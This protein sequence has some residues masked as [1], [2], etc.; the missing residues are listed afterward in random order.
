MAYLNPITLLNLDLAGAE[1]QPASEW[2]KREK[3]R[4]LAEFE[5]QDSPV[6][7]INEREIDRATVL[8]LF[9]SLEDHSEWQNHRLVAER[10]ALQAFLEEASLDLFYSGDIN[11]LQATTDEFRTFI[12]PHFAT[13]YNK[14]LLH[15]FRQIDKE[16]IEIM[17]VQPLPIPTTHLA[18]CYKDTY[19]NLHRRVS[20]IEALSQKVESEKAQPGGEVQEWCDEILIDVLNQLPAYFEGMRDRYGLALEELAIAIHNTHKRI[21][22]SI[23]ILRQ[24]LKLKV[25]EQTRQ[26]LQHVLDQL[27]LMAP[28]ASIFETISVSPEQKKAYGPILIGAGVVAVIW[29]LFKLLV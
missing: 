17:S 7:T 3:K 27:L 15:A 10:P 20:E 12:A 24:G 19:R 8:K 26:R 13:S 28:E 25:S 29:A 4:L 9:S 18:A 21:E 1:E 22:L 6:I 14:R 5:L 23:L 2:L 11:L 16:E